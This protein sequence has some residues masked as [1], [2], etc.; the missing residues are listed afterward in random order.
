MR[1]YGG[2]TTPTRSIFVRLVEN[3]SHRQ[4][5]ITPLPFAIYL[6]EQVRRR[7]GTYIVAALWLRSDSNYLAVPGVECYDLPRDAYTYAGPWPVIAH[8]PCG[9]HGRYRA[10]SRQ[11]RQAGYLALELATRYG[12][13]VEQPASSSL[14]LGGQV[15]R[16]HDFGHPSEKMT[17]LFWAHQP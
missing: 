15:V 6:V 3:L 1:A 17:R 10:V 16:Q 12:G 2:G 13:V 4:R 5:E 7:Y 9:P 14:F 8:P 11:D